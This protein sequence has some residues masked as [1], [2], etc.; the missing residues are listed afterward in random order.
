MSNVGVVYD[1]TFKHWVFPKDKTPIFLRNNASFY[2]HGIISKTKE[3]T[4]VP[5]Y[6]WVRKLSIY[7]DKYSIHTQQPNKRTTF[8]F[9][10]FSKI[11]HSVK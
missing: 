6:E 5:M 4:R 7:N 10:Q 11:L 1:P 2:T 8:F 3:S 9:F